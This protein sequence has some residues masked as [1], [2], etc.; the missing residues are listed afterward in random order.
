MTLSILQSFVRTYLQR[1][2]PA[3]ALAVLVLVGG[4][5][6]FRGLLTLDGLTLDPDALEPLEFLMPYLLGGGFVMAVAAY[7]GHHGL[8]RRAYA[9]PI[10]TRALG[11]WQMAASA[12]AI[13]GANLL[14][15][16]LLRQWLGVDWPILGPTLFLMTMVV[17]GHTAY[18]WLLDF[19]FWKAAV[20]LGALIAAGWWLLTRIQP[21]GPREPMVPWVL[22]IAD[23]L[24]LAA[25]T[26]GAAV[27]GSWALER[28]RHG[29]GRNDRQLDRVVVRSDDD[30]IGFVTRRE[31]THASPEEA[32]AWALWARTRLIA[33]VGGAMF[34]PLFGVLTLGVLWHDEPL[35]VEDALAMVLMHASVGGLLL[36]IV[37]SSSNLDGGTRSELLRAHVAA[38]PVSDRTLGRRLIVDALRGVTLVTSMLFVIAAIPLAVSMAKFGVDSAF[39]PLRSNESLARIGNGLFPLLFVGA[40]AGCWTV[41]GL[42][43]SLALTGRRKLVVAVFVTLVVLFV[44]TLVLLNFVLP[45]E[46]RDAA[47]MGLL[48]TIAAATTAG[49]VLALVV[50]ARRGLIGRAA[51]VCGAVSWAVAAVGL[52]ALVEPWGGRVI[53]AGVTSLIALPLASIPLAIAWNRHR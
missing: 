20:V 46:T 19:R 13:G 28:D 26:G 45:E 3:L 12:A 21:N 50:A 31:R 23:F 36:G 6:A 37:A 44:A 18:W 29:R 17:L 9:L 16:S 48:G 49:T 7:A 1:S 51:I 42:A 8:R 25:T 41:T 4:P 47:A 30:L 22:S 15:M 39:D 14:A 10:S 33:C 53:V 38:M 40:Y 43:A 34:V 32:L 24:V 2:L 52:A 5:L 35:D 27:F 11:A